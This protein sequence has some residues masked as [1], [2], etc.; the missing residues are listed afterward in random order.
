MIKHLEK[1]M[2]MSVIALAILTLVC[3]QTKGSQGCYT[4]LLSYASNNNIV[5][6]MAVKVSSI[7]C[8]EKCKGNIF[9]CNVIM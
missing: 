6:A 1:D 2:S 5:C 4:C 8:G 3:A 9:I 7:C